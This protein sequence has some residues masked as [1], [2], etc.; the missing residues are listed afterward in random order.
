MRN[1]RHRANV[2]AHHAGNVAR[3]VHGDGIKFADKIN[4]LRAHG[5]A[6]TALDAGV[7]ADLKEDGFFFHCK[8]LIVNC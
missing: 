8:Y 2:F 3:G 5:N 4:R 1:R 6:G 7:P